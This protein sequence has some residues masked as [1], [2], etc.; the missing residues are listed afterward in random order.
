MSLFFESEG[1]DLEITDNGALIFLDY[2]IDFDVLAYDMGDESTPAVDLFNDWQERPIPTLFRLMLLDFPGS[3]YMSICKKWILDATSIF[4][5]VGCINKDLKKRIIKYIEKGNFEE[6]FGQEFSFVS[7]INREGSKKRIWSSAL[8]DAVEK[9]AST[10]REGHDH[11]NDFFTILF[12]INRAINYCS[13]MIDRQKDIESLDKLKQQMLKT[14]I[15]AVQ[16]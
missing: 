14:V 7:Y 11:E 6:R 16:G 13:K 4:Y 9:Y 2:D 3:F 15:K 12:D 5:K 1:I 10:V 8:T